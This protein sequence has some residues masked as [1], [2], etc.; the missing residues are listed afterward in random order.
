MGL[1]PLPLLLLLGVAL[2]ADRAAGQALQLVPPRREHVTFADK[3]LFVSCRGSVT[4]SDP[5]G[6]EWLGPNGKVIVEGKGPVITPDES[7]TVD[8]PYRVQVEHSQSRSG[9]KGIDLMLNPVKRKDSGKYR[10]RARV[11]GQE[12]E[13]SFELIVL[14]P[15]QFREDQKVQF[16]AEGEDF[17]LRC[18]VTGEPKPVVNWRGVTQ[19]L[20]F[21][22]D[23][24]FDVD[25]ETKGLLIRDVTRQDEGKYRCKATQLGSKESDLQTS[26][27]ELK[28]QYKPE[29]MG[30]Q[31]TE[32]YGFLGGSANLSCQADAKPFPDFIWH[33]GDEIVERQDRFEPTDTETISVLQITS[34]NESMFGEY[35]CEAR[36]QYDGISRTIVLK[37]GLK[38]AIPQVK[39]T[40]TESSRLTLSITMAPEDERAD[41]YRAEYKTAGKANWEWSAVQ[42]QPGGPHVISGLQPDTDYT[43]RVAAV[44]QAGQ[45]DFSAGLHQRTAADRAAT[46]PANSSQPLVLSV[47]VSLLMAALLVL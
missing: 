26:D 27:I 35:R 28:V 25:P 19:S 41:L 22:A 15:I 2:L 38:P 30:P 24:K 1:Q 11:N 10:C 18:D 36:N 34:L 6:M 29:W 31:Q 37:K 7:D 17:L 9:Q 23:K 21:G 40:K 8:N 3:S 46:D 47:L 44:N 33:H 13:V 5:V 4:G 39:V 45:G 12:E 16:A 20:E 42:F 14:Q 32:V 43:I